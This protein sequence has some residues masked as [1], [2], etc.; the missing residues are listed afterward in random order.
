[1]TVA[2][3]HLDPTWS[4]LGVV[5]TSECSVA[6][7]GMPWVYVSTCC[8]GGQRAGPVEVGQWQVL[9]LSGSQ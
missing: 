7:R 6:H 1:M 2:C 3:L 4:A 9:Q 8:C 5:S